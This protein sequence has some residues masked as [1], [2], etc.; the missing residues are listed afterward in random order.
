MYI[1]KILFLCI[2]HRV[3]AFSLSRIKTVRIRIDMEPWTDLKHIK[4]PLYVTTW[5][6]P[7]YSK[8]LHH[9]G[10]KASSN[11]TVKSTII[12]YDGFRYT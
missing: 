5:D 1:K 4:G 7:K 8:G 2:F 3:L 10:V 6:A 11:L 12:V 9:M